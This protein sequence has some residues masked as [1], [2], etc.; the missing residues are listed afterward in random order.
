MILKDTNQIRN[1]LSYEGNESLE[2]LIQLSP[3]DIADLK[4]NDG[5]N[6]NTINTGNK[7]K[8]IMIQR[9]CDFWF[10]NGKDIMTEWNTIDKVLYVGT[11]IIEKLGMRFVSMGLVSLAG[12]L[13]MS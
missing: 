8:L 2:D 7:R 6:L 11:R 10:K 4:W 12:L 13:G 9:F 3:E 1:C 5:G